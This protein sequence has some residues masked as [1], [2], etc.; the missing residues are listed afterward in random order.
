MKNQRPFANAANASASSTAASIAIDAAVPRLFAVGARSLRDCFFFFFAVR[1]SRRPAP[2]GADPGIE[3]LGGASRFSAS[4]EA[5]DEEDVPEDAPPRW[6]RATAASPAWPP[7]GAWRPPGSWSRSP[8]SRR[9]AAPGF[10]PERRRVPQRAHERRH[11]GV[12]VGLGRFAERRDG[13]AGAVAG[14]ET[15]LLDVQLERQRASADS[16]ANAAASLRGPSGSSPGRRRARRP[17]GTARG[18]RGVPRHPPG[19]FLATTPAP[20]RDSSRTRTGRRGRG[21]RTLPKTPG[22]NRDRRETTTATTT[23]R[24]GKRS[25]RS[26]MAFDPRARVSSRPGSRSGP[27]SRGNARAASPRFPRFPRRTRRAPPA[28]ARATRAKPPASPAPASASAAPAS[29]PEREG[30][31]P[32]PRDG[33]PRGRRELRGERGEKP[34][35]GGAPAGRGAR[36]RGGPNPPL[37]EAENRRRPGDGRRRRRQRRERRLDD[38]EGVA[39]PPRSR[40]SRACRGKV[41][42]TH[43]RRTR[44]HRRAPGPGPVDGRP[45]PRGFESRHL[46]AEQSGPAR[47][48]AT[49]AG[50]RGGSPR[51]TSRA[52]SRRGGGGVS[53]S[54]ASGRKKTARTEAPSPSRARWPGTA[55]RA[56]SSSPRSEG[57]PFLFL[58]CFFFRGGGGAR[59]VRVRVRRRVRASPPISSRYAPFAFLPTA[60]RLRY[61]AR[62]ARRRRGRTRTRPGARRP[63]RSRRR[64]RTRDSATTSRFSSLRGADRLLSGRHRRTIR[65]LRTKTRG[66]RIPTIPSRSRRRR[67]CPAT[68]PDGVVLPE[69]PARLGPRR[70]P[71]ADERRRFRKRLLPFAVLAA[72][73]ADR[74]GD[75][76]SR[77]RPP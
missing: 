77:R 15:V 18:C 35:A 16:A 62:R 68:F 11:R 23:T 31:R 57:A 7:G 27:S 70:A 74:E 55:P 20:H 69:S 25:R 36:G 41:N 56:P 34:A 9:S 40:R 58:F 8:P 4:E 73:P 10:E 1:R 60:A 42:A 72:P 48:G 67:T 17:Q 3:S 21:W 22:K 12:R 28:R 33:H 53:T 75:A 47:I 71:R 45:D 51:R 37:G 59:R 38:E 46:R 24:G 13:T 5:R 66:T 6:R 61:G 29:A 63:A 49:R 54:S 52:R 65:A 19:R 30:E 76:Q 32:H 39:G 43:S 14:G 50:V 44:E 2:A 26:S 64:T